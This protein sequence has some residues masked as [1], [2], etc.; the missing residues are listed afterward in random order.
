M[1]T[2]LTKSSLKGIIKECLI[3]LLSEGLSSSPESLAESFTRGDIVKETIN[4]DKH[5]STK[6]SLNREKPR[7]PN[8]EKVAMTT[9]SS[10]TSDPIMA[11]MFADTAT[12]TLQEQ[13]QAE[14]KLPANRFGDSAAKKIDSIDDISEI[15]GES[16]GNWADLAFSEA[17]NKK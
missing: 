2:K 7:N 15:F 11:E 9:V 14:G 1:A 5:I 13:I 12:G 3:E 10:I 8:F 6:K 16:S 4:K 17:K